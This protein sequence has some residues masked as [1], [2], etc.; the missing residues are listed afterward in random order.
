MIS[1]VTHVEEI[2]EDHWMRKLMTD[3]KEKAEEDE[4]EEEGLW[5]TQV[6]Q[7]EEQE[8]K[9]AWVDCK[10]LH[11]VMHVESNEMMVTSLLNHELEKNHDGAR[12]QEPHC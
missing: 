1:L 7:E 10:M 8:E 11:L 3:A 2:E 4:E 9:E 12:H 5:M 6:D